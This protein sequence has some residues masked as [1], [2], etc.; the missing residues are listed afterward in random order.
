M[1][2]EQ[3]LVST[4]QA[5]R[6]CTTR[7][8]NEG[9]CWSNDEKERLELMFYSGTGISEM[10]VELQRTEPAVFQQIEKMDLYQR[11]E[12]PRRQR[13]FDREPKCL[14]N[15]CQL[16]VRFCPHC[17]DRRDGEEDV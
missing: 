1:T 12:N 17:K 2:N 10:A 5:I 16:D 14:C 3:N 7:L 15:N 11:K 13:F 9:A 8:K 4:I 6:K